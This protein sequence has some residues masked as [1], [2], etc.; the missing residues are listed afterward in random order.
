MFEDIRTD[1][2]SVNPVV[3]LVFHV[4]TVIH[5]LLYFFSIVSIIFMI[6]GIIISLLIAAAIR[7]ANQWEKGVILRMGKFIGLKGPGIFLVI[8]IIDRVAEYI[9]QRVRVTDITAE[10]TLTKDTVPVDVDAVVYWT[11]WD[12]EK[13]ALEVR[14]YVQAVTYM[15]LTGLRDTIGRH[16]LA[17]LLQHRDKIA[18]DLQRT[19]DEHTNP[20]GI[21]C[22]N[23]GIKDMIIPSA[24]SDAMS[25][26]AQAEREPETEA[27][28]EPKAEAERESYSERL[29][30]HESQPAAE[31][32]ANATAVAESRP[33]PK[34]VPITD[35]D[36][37]DLLL[38]F[39]YHYEF[40]DAAAFADL[41]ATYAVTPKARSR[42]YIRRYYAGVFANIKVHAVE[43]SDVYW[44]PG[45]EWRRGSATLSITT[46][47]ARGGEPSTKAQQV[48]FEVGRGERG[49]IEITRMSY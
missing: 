7:I 13:A 38:A 31:L 1:H 15:T 3:I 21:S 43:F 33:A 49:A 17:D 25:K 44:Q 30:E 11:V 45:A 20:W 42:K 29:P 32:V 28:P 36:L 22:Q 12:V 24:L 6:V 34:P 41:F 40:R 18:D 23:V 2:Q 47:P 37:E 8:P 48:S 4:L 5:I 16:E 26:Q 10:K 35:G 46:E 9:D 14:R 19:L 39:S 27:E